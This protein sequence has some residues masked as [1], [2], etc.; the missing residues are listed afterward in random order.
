MPQADFA[1][2]VAPH[3]YDP[4]R[5]VALVHAASEE[6]VRAAVQALPNLWCLTA[7]AMREGRVIVRGEAEMPR[8]IRAH[9]L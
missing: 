7:V 2:S 3:P 8:G 5:L 9:E 1:L 6:A 4:S